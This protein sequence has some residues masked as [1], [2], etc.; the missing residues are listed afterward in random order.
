MHEPIAPA[1]AK[2]AERARV[3][4]REEK[5]WIEAFIL[6]RS[7]L[8]RGRLAPKAGSSVRGREV[9]AGQLALASSPVAQRVVD[10]AGLGAR[11]RVSADTHLWRSKPP[12]GKDTLQSRSERGAIE[13]AVAASQQTRWEKGAY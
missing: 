7:G 2:R 13:R 5:G 3:A 9:A 10:V 11:L 4:V 12:G 8:T 6:T 1:E